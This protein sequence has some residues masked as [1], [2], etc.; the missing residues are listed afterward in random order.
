MSQKE[1][2][3]VSYQIGII[4]ILFFIFGFITW[5]NS[6]LIPYL[7][8]A[9]ELNDTQSY[10]VATAF[11]AAY[12]IMAIPSSWILKK[13]GFKNG[14]SLGLLVMAI[15][16]ILFI[17][18][19]QTRNYS[20]FL[21]GLF[22]IGT[23]LAL[24][25][26]AS[27]PFVTVLGPIESA[28]QRI[29]IMGICNKIAGIIAVY[30]LGSITLK[31]ADE[32]KAAILTMTPEAKA[33]ELDSLAAR[34]IQP[35]MMIAAVLLILAV[36]IYFIYLPEI[37]EEE[38]ADADA[39]SDKTSI[40]QFPHLLLGALAIFFYVGVEVISYDTFT[41]F[42]EFL[43]YKL[44]VARNFP[45]YTGYALLVGYVFNIVAIPRYISQQKA[46][47][48]LTI[49][50]MLL[51]VLSAF[52]G[53]KTAVICFLLLGFSNSV[54]WPAIWPLAIDGLGKFTKIGSALLIMGIVG[55][56]ILP[57]LYGKISELIGNKQIAYLMMIPAYL[58]ILY[59]ALK[60]H[61]AGRTQPS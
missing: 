25:Q 56:A 6:S 1:T 43:G 49:I 8:L 58:Y 55:G 39:T 12:F 53:G 54:M 48:W 42:G 13:T 11:F 45:T 35:Y 4:G 20:L 15:G 21:L 36:L 18:A 23:G 33:A 60:G 59:Y 51:V 30:V 57:P 44:D 41:G 34:V 5:A 52:T 61:Q 2:P 16:A 50:S 38:S 7:K 31:N 46:L 19:A 24:L 17:P 26:T 47:Y 22:I 14:M 3:S 10:Y 29:S 9:C 27:N 28:A 32:I 37:K 40:L